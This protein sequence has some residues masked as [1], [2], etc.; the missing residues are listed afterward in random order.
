MLQ[1]A[2]KRSIYKRLPI[3]LDYCKSILETEPE[4]KYI[5]STR[6]AEE[7]FLGEVQVRKDLSKAC[8]A[9]RPKVG[10]SLKYLIQSI[11]KYLKCKDTK[12]AIMIGVGKLGSAILGFD[13]LKKYGLD[14]VAGFDTNIENKIFN[15]PVFEFTEEN[16]KEFIYFCF[17]TLRGIF[18]SLTSNFAGHT[19]NITILESGLSAL[20]LSLW[21]KITEGS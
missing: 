6:I 5:S 14:I 13:E 16:I 8:G 3:Y 21:L 20:C 12:N 17:M 2:T 4:T 7:L 10:Y 19:E 11:E 9:G 18:F 15:K 1:N